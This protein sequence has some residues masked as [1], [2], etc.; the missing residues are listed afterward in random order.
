[1]VNLYAL[2]MTPRGVVQ[3]H[4]RIRSNLAARLERIAKSNH[5]S[6]ASE[7]SMIVEKYLADEGVWYDPVTRVQRAESAK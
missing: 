6:L 3:I 4:L 7:V 1:M 5:R 2:G